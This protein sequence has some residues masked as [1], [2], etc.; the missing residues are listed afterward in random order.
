MKKRK[1]EAVKTS[2]RKT[3]AVCEV[4]GYPNRYGVQQCRKCNSS[5]LKMPW[6]ER[7]NIFKR[8]KHTETNIKKLQF[9]I[10]QSLK[11]P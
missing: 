9:V 2:S 4:C 6:Y 5:L 7:I 10:S 11:N 3:Q 8:I 1:E